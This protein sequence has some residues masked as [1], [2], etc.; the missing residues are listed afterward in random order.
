MKKIRTNIYTIQKDPFNLEDALNSIQDSKDSILY[1]NCTSSLR[2]RNTKLDVQFDTALYSEEKEVLILLIQGGKLS[3]DDFRKQLDMRNISYHEVVFA[4]RNFKDIEKEKEIWFARDGEFLDNAANDSKRKG[5]D[6]C[7]F[8][9]TI[10]GKFDIRYNTDSDGTV[11]LGRQ[12]I[13]GVIEFEDKYILLIN[14]IEDCNVYY[15]K[16]LKILAKRGILA[17]MEKDDEWEVNRAIKQYK[18]EL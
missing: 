17:T 8:Y 12:E 1:T 9:P 5:Y 3:S 10:K 7:S 16:A 2:I 15:K 18:K 14:H 13:R 11:V 6:V 4:K